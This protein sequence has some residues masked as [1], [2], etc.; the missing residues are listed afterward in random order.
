MMIRWNVAPH[1]K[2]AKIENAHQLATTSGLA[3]PIV[4]RILQG[5]HV[6]RIDTAT[7][8]KLAGALD[9]KRPLSLLEYVAD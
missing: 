7:L 1:M 6:S 4:W 2:R 9:V 5:E 3:Y 8:L